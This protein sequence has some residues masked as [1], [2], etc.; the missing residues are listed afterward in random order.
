[1]SLRNECEKLLEDLK[2]DKKGY[3]NYQFGRCGTHDNTYHHGRFDVLEDT[4]EKLEQILDE[5]EEK[6]R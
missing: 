1:M 2:E 3:K 5:K 4:V 6:K